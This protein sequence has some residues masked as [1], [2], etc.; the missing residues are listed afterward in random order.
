MRSS[1][2]LMLEKVCPKWAGRKYCTISTSPVEKGE[3]VPSSAFPAAADR[4]L[5]SLLAGL[6]QPDQEPSPPTARGE[7]AE[8]RASARFSK[9]QPAALCSRCMKHRAR[10]DQLF[11]EWDRARRRA[12]VEH[13]VEMV[14]LTPARD[15]RPKELSGGMRQRVAV[16]R[17]LRWIRR[18][19]FA[20]NR[21]RA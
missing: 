15:K 21:S 20:T 17:A 4:R 8:F 12:H 9:L 16:A 18:C 14:N 1:K 6:T 10:G 13:Y 7:G 2:W 11:P 3:F 5:M 19:C